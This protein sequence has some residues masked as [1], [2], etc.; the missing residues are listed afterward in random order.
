[1]SSVVGFQA[2]LESK[3]ISSRFPDVAENED[4]FISSKELSNNGPHPTGNETIYTKQGSTLLTGKTLM[5]T[6]CKINI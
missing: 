1:M 5:Q 4:F 2:V 3:G 6:I